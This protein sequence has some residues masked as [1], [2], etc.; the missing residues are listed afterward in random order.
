MARDIAGGA[1]FS[2]ARREL[3]RHWR[4]LVALGV[5]AGFVGAPVVG[6]LVLA[7]RTA[8][9]YPRLAQAM[10]IEDVHVRVRDR[11]DAQAVR[12]LPGVRST[13]T[14]ELSVGRL[15]GD[16]VVYAGVL[17]GSTPVGGLSRPVVVAGRAP[18]PRTASEVLLN[19]EY[20]RRLRVG[21]GDSFRISMLTPDEIEQFDTGF[22]APDGPT[23][24]LTVTGIARAPATGATSAPIIATPTF[25]TTYGD[26]L[27]AGPI[28][29]V[30]LE[31]GTA[32]IPAFKAALARL[33]R[34][35]PR[36]SNEDDV[37]FTAFTANYPSEE[38]ER[39]DAAS[40]VLVTGLL[41]FGGVA[42]LAG[43]VLCVLAFARHQA[44]GSTTQRIESVVGL[45][46]GER[47]LARV[48]PALLAA[49]VAAVLTFAGGVAAG[50]FEP[51]GALHRNEPRPG[52]APN[53]GFVVAGSAVAFVV[54]LA[55]AGVTAFRAGGR[56]RA[57]RRVVSRR[58]QLVPAND[59]T[60]AA[61]L[62][63]A[64][65]RGRAMRTTIAAVALGLTL[66]VAAASFTAGLDR[67]TSSRARYGW[68]GD[69]AVIDSQSGTVRALVDDPRFSAVGV[70]ASATVEVAA[71]PVVA[72]SLD[73]PK[74]TMTWTVLEGRMPRTPGEVLIGS[75]L[76]RHLDVSTGERVTAGRP[77]GGTERLRIVGVGIGPVFE[78]ES[79]GRSIVLTRDDLDAF[80]AASPFVNAIVRVDGDAD[81]ARVVRDLELRY[82][83]A[84]AEPP[85]EV[86]NLDDLSR[87][88]E[89]VA[90]LVGAVA[91]GALALG[92]AGTLRARSRDVAL[93]RALGLTPRQ[94]RRSIAIAGLVVGAIGAVIGVAAGLLAG[95]VLWSQVA[96]WT[97]VATDGAVPVLVVFIVPGAAAVAAILAL[98]VGRQSIHRRPARLLTAE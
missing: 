57:P 95:R 3:R 51:L 80:A 60:T 65:G 29:F 91:L 83:V 13:W 35:E 85:P 15:A 75:R 58:G 53:W 67:L 96:Q 23:L 22:G 43:I 41:V 66:V 16:N 94:A 4:M 39:L 73:V 79:L 25:S 47:T 63:L 90:L 1:I 82:E 32:S 18:D 40:R 44:T 6:A 12:Q 19:E 48:L 56:R 28:V 74:G 70:V 17:S 49:L 86:T 93:L 2:V 81:P 30:R 78:N 98:V 92:V 50:R 72:Y 8:T 87:L 20:A 61:G 5:L 68:P 59:P 77:D 33:N 46:R 34:A 71:D 52:W 21:P 24:L 88:P 55:I 54:V 26:A 37:D 89:V 9:A 31:H 10:Q 36:A 76:A 84:R 45:T 62:D 97:G 7:R 14:G 11:A 27:A 38:T 64:F 42:L 69:A